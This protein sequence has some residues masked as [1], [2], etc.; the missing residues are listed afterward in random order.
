MAGKWGLKSHE[1]KALKDRGFKQVF[2]KNPSS[3]PAGEPWGK[4]KH[5]SGHTIT[6]ERPTGKER[7]RQ[8]HTTEGLPGRNWKSTTP[9]GGVAALGGT[10]YSQAGALSTH[11]HRN[12]PKVGQDTE[13][14]G[15][16]AAPPM[17]DAMDDKKSKGHLHPLHTY[18]C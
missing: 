12:F 1:A 3:T 17:M 6:L 14:T 10:S 13:V 11:L 7:G 9:L 2:K 16:T 18:K 5:P 4:F 8:A 15:K